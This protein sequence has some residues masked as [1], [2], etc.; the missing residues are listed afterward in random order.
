MS[1]Q[2][3]KSKS[4]KTEGV[5]II[6]FGKR[7]YGFAAINLAVS[8]KTFNPKIKIH[9]AYEEQTMSQVPHHVVDRFFDSTSVIVVD[10]MEPAKLKWKYM[11][12]SP[13]YRTL[14]LDADG[15]ALK[16]VAPLFD[17]FRGKFLQV[18]YMGQGQK[19]NTGISYDAWSDEG[20]EHTYTTFGIPETKDWFTCQTSFVY[21]EQGAKWE[22]AQ[23]EI[24]ANFDK[25]FDRSLMRFQWGGFLPDELM[26]S[27]Y[28]SKQKDPT[29]FLNPKEDV[30]FFP[31]QI[32]P[33]SDVC[34]NYFILSLYG[35][36]R[37]RSLVR[38]MWFEYYDK[39]LIRHYEKHGLEHW[40]KSNIVMKDKLLSA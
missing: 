1:N 12:D 38:P 10:E 27:V 40:Y 24:L 18:Q 29:A 36:D 37:G 15:M 16:D 25:P 33:I 8:I 7:G 28:I 22:K 35:S 21:F 31:S 17:K 23:K 32:Q 11:A 13:F 5:L 30:I 3:K 34:D 9:L 20:H 26:V 2:P 4:E 39:M 6:A 14:F 19:G